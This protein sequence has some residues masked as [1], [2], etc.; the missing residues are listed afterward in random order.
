MIHYVIQKT[1]KQNVDGVFINHFF[2]LNRKLS[3]HELYVTV[4]LH[5]FELITYPISPIY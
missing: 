4:K 1:V 5:N 2:D 3:L